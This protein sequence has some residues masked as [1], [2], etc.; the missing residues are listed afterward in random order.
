MCRHLG[1]SSMRVDPL[2][3][4]AVKGQVRPSSL[5]P[6]FRKG[7]LDLAVAVILHQG[8]D[9]VGCDGIL[10]RRGGDQVVERGYLLEYSVR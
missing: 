8:V 6:S 3:P 10:A 5:A 4:C 1:D 2:R 9:H 7:G